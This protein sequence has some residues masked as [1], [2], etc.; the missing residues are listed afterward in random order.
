MDNIVFGSQLQRQQWNQKMKDIA[1][2]LDKMNS[3]TIFFHKTSELK[4]SPC[5]KIQIRS[6]A[7]LKCI[8]NDKF[9]CIQ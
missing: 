1:W 2:R 9:W 8:N 3:R 7:I 5:K 4:D 6:W